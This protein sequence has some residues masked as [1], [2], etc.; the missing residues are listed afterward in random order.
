M[1]VHNGTISPYAQWQ[2]HAVAKVGS[3]V[4][5]DWHAVWVGVFSRDYVGEVVV[6][7]GVVALIVGCFHFILPMVVLS[8]CLSSSC[9]MG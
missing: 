8:C 7:V 2:W 1:V 4:W 3:H 9:S 6:F 5:V